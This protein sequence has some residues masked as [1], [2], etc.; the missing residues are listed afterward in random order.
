MAKL[1]VNVE[2]TDTDI[3]GMRI[4]LAHMVAKIP[5]GLKVKRWHFLAEIEVEP[6]DLTQTVSDVAVPEQ[7]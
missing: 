7:A 3:S 4:D 1:F 5:G 6:G 2:K